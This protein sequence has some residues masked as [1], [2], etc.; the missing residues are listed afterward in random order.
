MAQKLVRYIDKIEFK[1]LLAAEKDKRYKLMY[2]LGFGSG[3][4][5]SEVIGYKGKSRKKNKAGEIIEADVIIPKLTQD[6]IDLDKHSIRILGKRGKERITMTS[7]W[8]NKTNIKLLPIDI[9]RRTVQ[10]RISRLGE[11][12]LGRKITFH[13]LRH[14]W[15]NHLLNVRKMSVAQVQMLGGWSRMDTLGIYAKANPTDAINEAFEVF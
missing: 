10:G 9:S 11:R 5:I 3:L 1:K 12:V 8:M 13:T 14:G 2:V 4:R 7:P 6:K 15:A